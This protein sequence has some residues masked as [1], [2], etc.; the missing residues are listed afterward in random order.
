MRARLHP[1][2]LLAA[3]LAIPLLLLLACPNPLGPARPRLSSDARLSSLALSTGV[4]NPVFAADATDYSANIPNGE[5][6]VTVT[7]SCASAEATL[8]VNG[9]ATPQGVASADILVNAGSTASIAVVVTAE[10]GTTTRTYTVQVS[11]AAADAKA[12]TAFSFRKADNPDLPRDYVGVIDEG[13]HT[14]T[15]NV[16]GDTD[17]SS[18]IPQVVFSG[19]SLSPLS[20]AAQDFSAP[21][22]YTVTAGDSSTQGYAV[23]VNL[24]P[25]T[26][27]TGTVTLPAPDPDAPLAAYQVTLDSWDNYYSADLVWNADNQQATYTFDQE[28]IEGTYTLEVLVDMNGDFD[29][30]TGDYHGEATGIVVPETGSVTKNLSLTEQVLATVTGTITLPAAD[31]GAPG[32]ENDVQLSSSESNYFTNLVWSDSQTA[33]YT[34]DGVVAAGTYTLEVLV[35]MDGDLEHSNGDY[36]GEATGIVVPETGSV[37]RPS[38]LLSKLSYATVS[39]TLTIP[40][41]VAEGLQADIAFFNPAGE[42]CGW[43]SVTWGAGTTATFTA[44]TLP[45]GTY[46]MRVTIDMDGDYAIG[47]GDYVG[48]YGGSGLYPPASATLV[49]PASGELTGVNVALAAYPSATGS[50]S[51]TLTI[52][53]GN[54]DG[55]MYAAIV[56]T[57]GI[58]GSFPG[59]IT[60]G[61][62]LW[63]GSG[64]TATYT[65]PN[66]PAGTFYIGATVVMHDGGGPPTSGD[67]LG[68]YGGSGVN[69]PASRNVTVTAGQ[70]VTGIDFNLAVVP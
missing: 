60:M 8:T 11:R 62:Y 36:Y 41:A 35:D 57:L 22:I 69:P 14:I 26:T 61:Q 28:V 56:D 25:L 45:A 65:I 30:S 52:P 29:L 55:R 50:V 7:A 34:F 42:E 32:V 5:T 64:L 53:A 67:Y 17:R 47:D 37:T 27:V 46:L 3:G 9:A 59:I 48:W 40:A 58:K 6:G 18:L 15:V 33:T 39:G 63:S 51:G 23:T 31:A 20:G 70:A 54:A 66:V 12:I 1:K 68:Y 13:A 38:M 44:N 2:W 43:T 16:R 49:V 10:D 19:D 24:V 4:L 21:V